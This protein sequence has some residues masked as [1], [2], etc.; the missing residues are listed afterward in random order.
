MVV[1]DDPLIQ[2]ALGSMLTK[3]GCIAEK[4]MNGQ[5]A[6]EMV[7]E[8]RSKGESCDIIFMDVNMPV[9]NGYEATKEIKKNED[10]KTAVICS[11][12]QDT[13]QHQNLCKDA[14][15]DDI[16]H[17]PFTIKEIKRVLNKYNLK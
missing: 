17:K 1:D 16:V 15:M 4:A 11:S 10:M 7:N 3:L 14:G 2:L 13:L 5:L 6:I 9:M 8:K 12:G